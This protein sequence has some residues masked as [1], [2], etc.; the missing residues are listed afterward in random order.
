MPETA[1]Q[2][3]ADSSD[4]R[5]C[6]V[7]LGLVYA[8]LH[9]VWVVED[10]YDSQF[11]YGAR[12]A[13][14]FQGLGQQGRV[15]YLGTFSKT[16]FPALRLAYVVAPPDLVEGF[17]RGLNELYREGQLQQQAVL[18]RFLTKGHY[19][20]HVRRIRRV[21]SARRDALIHAINSHF[22]DCLPVIGGHAGL[23]LVLGL[24]K[25]IDDVAVMQQVLRAGLATRPLSHYYL[26]QPAPAKGLLLGYGAVPE[27]EIER[28]FALRSSAVQPFL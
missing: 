4:S 21:Y 25:E 28:N 5:G 11:R 23:H 20:T 7:K 12:P 8:A 9:S 17:G 15:I 14:A 6:G 24:P 10:D 1:R 19:A 16:L 13:P 26:Q 3:P 22:G 27:E 2:A 18:A